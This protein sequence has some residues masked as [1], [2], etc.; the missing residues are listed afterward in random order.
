MIRGRS[1]SWAITNVSGS[2]QKIDILVTRQ[3]Q[4]SVSTTFQDTVTVFLAKSQLQ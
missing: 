1:V 3:G 2:S 4:A